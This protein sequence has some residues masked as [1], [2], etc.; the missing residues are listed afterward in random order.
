MRQVEDVNA[1]LEQ[2]VDFLRQ[3]EAG[4]YG[5]PVLDDESASWRVSYRKR[6]RSLRLELVRLDKQRRF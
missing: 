3:L 1:D 2:T 4:P 6:E 5:S